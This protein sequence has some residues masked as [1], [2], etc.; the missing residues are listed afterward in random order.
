MDNAKHVSKVFAPRY[1]PTSHARVPVALNSQQHLAFHFSH[2]G[3]YIWFLICISLISKGL[4]LFM[5]YRSFGYLLLRPLPIFSSGFSVFFSLIY[6]NSLPILK[7]SFLLVICTQAESVAYYFQRE[8]H[9]INPNSSLFLH[10]SPSFILGSMSLALYPPL[11]AQ[12]PMNI[13]Y[14]ISLL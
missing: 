13:S 7:T 10:L 11:S 3:L 14:F 4:H 1:P 12:D 5:C 9:A 8:L 2:F 6:R